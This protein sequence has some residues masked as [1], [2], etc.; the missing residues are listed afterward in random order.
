MRLIPAF[1][2]AFSLLAVPAYSQDASN[3]NSSSGA[4]SQSGVNIRYGNGHKQV[5][6]A[7]APGLAV[8]GIS[9][10][11]SVA[12]GAGGSGWGLSF[13]MTK[14]DRDCNLR[15]NARIVGLMGEVPA[16]REIMCNVPEV[17]AAFATV[18]RP[19]AADRRRAIAT[20]SIRKAKATGSIRRTAVVQ[21]RDVWKIVRDR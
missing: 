10:Q 8:G 5:G 11:G 1:L 15:E 16:A 2:L 17:R 4:M 18:G 19:C 3:S 12:A 20:G 6:A 14:M 7:I 21:R 13:G 9:C